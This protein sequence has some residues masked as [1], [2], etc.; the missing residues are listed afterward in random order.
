MG[1]DF[2]GDARDR[3]NN[4][5]RPAAQPATPGKRTLTDGLSPMQNMA[6]SVQS[7]TDKAFDLGG[8]LP[9][10]NEHFNKVLAYGV[11]PTGIPDALASMLEATFPGADPDALRAPLSGLDAYCRLT[12]WSGS[13]ISASFRIP[14][15]FKAD[16]SRGFGGGHP[17]NVVAD[18][19]SFL[20]FSAVVPTGTKRKATTTTKAEGNELRGRGTREATEDVSRGGGTVPFTDIT[21]GKETKHTSEETNSESRGEAFGETT[22]TE[23]ELEEFEVTVFLRTEGTVKITDVLAPPVGKETELGETRTIRL[24]LPFIHL[25]R[26]RIVG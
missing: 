10:P 13:G 8:R 6:A 21:F 7:M 1:K 12:G 17:A 20:Y 16:V 4:L 15:D 26:F 23:N 25:G 14:L 24:K 3:L 19:R 5:T 18:L 9:A 22:T 2:L 11:P